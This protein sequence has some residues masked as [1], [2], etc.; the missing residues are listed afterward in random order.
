MR[1]RTEADAAVSEN[2]VEGTELFVIVCN[3]LGDQNSASSKSSSRMTVEGAGGREVLGDWE[4]LRPALRIEEADETWRACLGTGKAS[5]RPSEVAELAD[6][7]AGEC[8]LPTG[9][10]ESIIPPA[11]A[12]RCIGIGADGF[13]D[14]RRPA[15][16]AARD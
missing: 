4:R 16:D 13:A 7:N 12:R 5:E 14:S 1:E 15:V 8:A 11:E 10:T 2:E 3:A 9:D 6:R